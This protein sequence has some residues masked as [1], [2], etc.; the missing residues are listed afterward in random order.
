MSTVCAVGIRTLGQ[1]L[2]QRLDIDCRD[3]ERGELGFPF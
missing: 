1:I 2:L 3:G